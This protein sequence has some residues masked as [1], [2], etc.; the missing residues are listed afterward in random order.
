[1]VDE[2]VCFPLQVFP[3]FDG[4]TAVTLTRVEAVF[5]QLLVSPHRRN[6]NLVP[7]PKTDENPKYFLSV[8]V[9]K[10]LWHEERNT[11]V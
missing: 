1:M 4:K 10:A 5:S 2:L 3:Q 9:H 11:N 8:R 7:L 6:L